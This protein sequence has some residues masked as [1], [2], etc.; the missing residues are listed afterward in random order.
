MPAGTRWPPRFN[1]DDSQVTPVT[2]ATT[3]T[4]A[5]LGPGLFVPCR[6]PPRIGAVLGVGA[7]VADRDGSGRRCGAGRGAGDADPVVHR[8]GRTGR[9]RVPAVRRE[10]SGGDAGGGS[11]RSGRGRN[12]AG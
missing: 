6:A 8:A 2:R 7:C 1:D 3:T 10:R 4:P 9:G 11:V 5:L 12:A